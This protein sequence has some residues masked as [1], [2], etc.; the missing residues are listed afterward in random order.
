MPADI[1][2]G[3]NKSKFDEDFV[4]NYHENSNTGY[5]LE[6]DVEYPRKLLNLHRDLPLLAEKLR[7]KKR[8]KLVCISEEKKKYAVYI[9]TLK[10]AL[11][12]G[13]ILR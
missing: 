9:R 8:N 11:N 1:L 13:L 6:V 10:Q 3:K 5:I 12:H 7:I 4:K 2:N